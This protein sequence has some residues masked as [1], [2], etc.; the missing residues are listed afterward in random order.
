MWKWLQHISPKQHFFFS[1][2]LFLACGAGAL[3][4]RKNWFLLLPFAWLLA[5]VLLHHVRLVW[6]LLIFSIP[7]STETMVT[8]SLGLDVP[9]EPLMML[10][11]GIG[12][13][14]LVHNPKLINKAFLTNGLW[15]LLMLHLLW[16]LI[17][18]VF[19]VNPML[20]IKYVLAKTWFVVPFVVL[21]NVLLQKTDD[22]LLAAKYFAVPMLLVAVQ[23]IVRHAFTGFSFEGI[24]STTE[25]FFRN[26]VNYSAVL[27]CVAAILAVAIWHQYK[28]YKKRSLVYGL[29]LGVCLLGIVLAYS[30]GAW[31]ATVAGGIVAVVIYRRWLK[32]LMLFGLVGILLGFAWLVK[33]NNYLQYAHNYNN[34]IFH[35]DLEA[36]LQAT[37]QL[38]DVSNAER[39]YRWVAGI[40]M[41]RE[42]L[43]AGY[44]PNN[45]FPHYKGYTVAAFRTWVSENEDH[46]SAHNYFITLLVEQG[47]PGLVLFTVLF[48]AMLLRSQRLFHQLQNKVQQSVALCVGILLTIVGCEIFMND[49]IETDKIGSLFFLNLGVLIWLSKQRMKQN[50]IVDSNKE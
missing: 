33:D 37:W 43:V 12:L 35:S 26:H 11:T 49:L 45:F 42:H 22:L 13:L 36:H 44:G 19:S 31:V 34:T 41:S 29:A 39:F 10:L 2:L 8:A 24:K 9:D 15:Q 7:L 14:A 30:R 4:L 1:T 40:R 17:A 50:L 20:S 3:L 23:A 16:M 5:Q 47:I 18:C 32:Q 48:L 38:Q 27:V 25:P 46:S 28:Y 21:L 6:Y